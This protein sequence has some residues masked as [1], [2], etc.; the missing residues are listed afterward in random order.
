MRKKSY[1]MREPKKKMLNFMNVKCWVEIG[2]ITHCLIVH[3]RSDNEWVNE[4]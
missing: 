3:F 4:N 2:A 1:E